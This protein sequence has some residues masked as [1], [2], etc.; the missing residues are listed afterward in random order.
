MSNKTDHKTKSVCIIRAV[1]QETEGMLK[2][3][4]T[5]CFTVAEDGNYHISITEDG[6]F[7][8][9][10]SE[11]ETREISLPR[12]ISSD[13]LLEAIR[14]IPI[15]RDI[16]DFSSDPATCSAIL[17]DTSV[18]L[19]ETEFRLYSALLENRSSFTSAKTLSEAVWGRYDRNLC[20][21]Y[22]SYLRRKLNSTFGEGT[23]ITAN[24]KGYRLQ[25]TR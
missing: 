2:A 21:V 22:I 14:E 8:R 3:I 15:H 25:S 24:G 16:A 18:N 19:T 10:S 6:E 12:P 13:A 11:D 17:G 20:T 4:L 9:I 7:F 5:Q 1:T 23:L